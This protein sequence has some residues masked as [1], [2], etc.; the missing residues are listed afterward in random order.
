M[1]D[2]SLHILDIVENSIR[3]DAHNVE[4][5]LSENEESNMLILKIVDDGKGMNN[6]TLKNA[7]NPFFTTKEGKKFGLGLSLLAQASE[8][9]GGDIKV[10]KRGDRGT[11]ITVSFIRDHI[12]LKPLGDIEKT[13]RVLRATHPDVNFSFED[14]IKS[15]SLN[16]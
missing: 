10:E 3:A 9:A 13:L 2:L 12:D 4:I 5:Q 6:Q 1:E 11:R 15:E 14:L 8:E 7:A 16:D